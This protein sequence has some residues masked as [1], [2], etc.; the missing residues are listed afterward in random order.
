MS[1]P[2]PEV[3][4]AALGSRRPYRVAV[5]ASHVIQYQGPL[6]QLLAKHPAIELT[7][8]F[9]SR[10][11]LQSYRDQGFGQQV[12]WD[13]PLLDGYRSHFLSNWSPRPNPSRFWGLMNPAIV[14][15]LKPADFDAVWVHGWAHFTVW[16]AMLTAFARRIPLLMRAEN[17]LLSP[18]ARWKRGIKRV[19]L[20]KLFRRVDGFLA[21]GSRN[22]E[23]YRVHGVSDSRIF[24]VPYA[25]NNNLFISQRAGNK[26]QIKSELGIASDA[27][28]ILFSGKLIPA[29]RPQDLLR[30]FQGIAAGQR[31]ALIFLGDGP[32]RPSLEKYVAD[33]GL[34]NVHFT[35]FRNQTELARFFTAADIFVLPSGLERWGLVVNE[36]MCF[37]L[38]IIASDQV[39]AARDLVREGENGFVYPVGDIPALTERLTRLM[40]NPGLRDA[41]GQK[42]RDMIQKWSYAQDVEG[43]IACL[44]GLD[45]VRDRRAAIRSE[46]SSDS[47]E[48]ELEP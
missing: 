9:C 31:A 16:L 17:N 18:V 35:G 29:K 11:G 27:A 8:L 36:A 32:R 15:V 44:K 38:P 33:E 41:M 22:A 20:R 46:R 26:T 4:A 24:L 19:M 40:E 25:V 39:G 3:K 30:A 34:A 23:F 2:N 28:V 6:Y 37:G 5:L 45:S 1:K 48:P 10:Q 21:V 47:A 13:V 42:S 14:S 12:K 43:V 7:V